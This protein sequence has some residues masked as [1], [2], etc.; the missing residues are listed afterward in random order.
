M[1]I[2]I[3][4]TNGM[5]LAGMFAGMLAG[6]VPGAVLPVPSEDQYMDEETMMKKE[7][8][9]EADEK[10]REERGAD[11]RAIRERT[12]LTQERFSDL[13]GIPK[14]TLENWETGSRR[15]PEYVVALLER[16]V[17]Q[18]VQ[19]TDMKK[20]HK[21]DIL[22]VATGKKKVKFKGCADQ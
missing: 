2:T 7:A 11:V 20:K 10:M 15:P 9:M 14:R 6:N 13:Y 21:Q 19:I 17:D 22:D 8:Q 3:K 16:A 5:E 1:E 12:G 4:A 18:D